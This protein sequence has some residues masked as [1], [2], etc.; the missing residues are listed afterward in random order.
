MASNYDLWTPPHRALDAAMVGGWH[1]GWGRRV[2]EVSAPH[3]TIPI[4]PTKGASTFI[5]FTDHTSKTV[6]FE[7]S[8]YY[9]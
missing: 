1:E 7:G 4:I 8:Q 9:F 2:E 6:S 5:C 3:L